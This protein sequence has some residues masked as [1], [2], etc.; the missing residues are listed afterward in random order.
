MPR[1]SSLLDNGGGEREGEVIEKQRYIWPYL[2]AEQTNGSGPAT[3][4]VDLGHGVKM[5]FMRIPA[6]QFAMGDL[7]GEADERPLSVVN[8][9]KPFWMSKYEVSNDHSH[10]LVFVR[11]HGPKA[12]SVLDVNEFGFF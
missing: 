7:K 4:T 5:E 12:A 2:G 6:G 11:A 3:R 1:Q 10:R 8:I 9:A